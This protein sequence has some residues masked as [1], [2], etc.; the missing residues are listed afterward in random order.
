MGRVGGREGGDM[1]GFLVLVMVI[2]ECHVMSC[3]LT[4]GFSE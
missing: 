2:W 1:K 4:G 3:D